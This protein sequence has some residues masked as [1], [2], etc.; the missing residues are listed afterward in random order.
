MRILKRVHWHQCTR[1]T[2][3]N[4]TYISGLRD[5]L[6]TALRSLWHTA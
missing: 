1:F 6:F 4:Q 2:L 3:H 5:T